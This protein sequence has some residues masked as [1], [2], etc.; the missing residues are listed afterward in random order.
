MDKE[1]KTPENLSKRY[2]KIR[3]SNVFLKQSIDAGGLVLKLFFNNFIPIAVEQDHDKGP[4]DGVIYYG[5]S[6]LFDEIPEGSRAFEYVVFFTS[7]EEG[8][9]EIK[10]QRED[11]RDLPPRDGD[12]C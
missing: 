2:G 9:L 5:Y 3:V 10:F 6:K 1:I 11:Q 12:T 8:G 4:Y 7:K